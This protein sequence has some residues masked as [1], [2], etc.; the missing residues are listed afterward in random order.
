M[1]AARIGVSPTT[2]ADNPLGRIGLGIRCGLV[3]R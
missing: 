2:L 1:A 3:E